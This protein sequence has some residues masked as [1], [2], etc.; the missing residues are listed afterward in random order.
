MKI[1][2]EKDCTKVIE[3]LELLKKARFS[4][5][6]AAEMYKYIGHLQSFVEAINQFKKPTQPVD[7]KKLTPITK[8]GKG[9]K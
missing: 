1:E 5:F 6:S 2:N 9:K 3:F 4:D 7:P 8:G